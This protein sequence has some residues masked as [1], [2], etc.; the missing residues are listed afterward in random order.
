MTAGSF[1]L[2]LLEVAVRSL[3]RDQDF[4]VSLDVSEDVAAGVTVVTGTMSAG[5]TAVLAWLLLL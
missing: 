4:E 3:E 2:A 5:G 1:G